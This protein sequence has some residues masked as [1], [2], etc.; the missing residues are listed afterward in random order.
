VGDRIVFWK[1]YGI[2]RIGSYPISTFVTLEDRFGGLTDEGTVL[3]W[4]AEGT[5]VTSFTVDH[6]SSGGM[7]QAASGGDGN[8]ILG[9][10]SGELRMFSLQDGSLLW[11][12]GF[13]EG[14]VSDVAMAMGHVAVAME[15]GWVHLVKA[16]T[17]EQVTCIP[18][19][20]TGRIQRWGKTLLVSDQRSL[21]AYPLPE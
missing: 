1:N 16:D 15:N 14:P 21:Y 5:L 6:G 8:L 3:L 20:G 10:R 18:T 9:F 19:E 2:T 11:C 4:D 12:R 17:G 7:V 13:G